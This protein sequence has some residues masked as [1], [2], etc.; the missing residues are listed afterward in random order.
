MHLRVD[1][2]TNLRHN[3]VW[4]RKVILNYIVN[5]KMADEE[6]LSIFYQHSIKENR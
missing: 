1:T 3:Q 6:S 4:I 5:V 2:K